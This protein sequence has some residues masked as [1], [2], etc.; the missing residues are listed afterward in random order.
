M[1]E[2]D[3]GTLRKVEWTEIC[4]WLILLRCFRM[5]IGFRLLLLATAGA[6]ATV[7]GW[8]LILWVFSGDPRIEVLS[9]N[10]ILADE[11]SI[12]DTDFFLPAAGDPRI[13]ASSGDPL[14][15]L[16][17]LVP[18]APGFSQGAEGVSGDPRIEFLSGDPWSALT[19]LVP[20][21]L[22]FSQGAM[23]VLDDTGKSVVERSGDP[24]LGTWGQLSRPLREVFGFPIFTGNGATLQAGEG[25]PIANLACFLLCGLWGLVVWAFFGGAITRSAAVELAC[26]ERIGFGRMIGYARAR[27]RSYVG[28]P[29]L[30]LVVVL[31]FAFFMAIAGLALRTDFTRFLLAVI[32]PLM[33]VG[34]VSMTWLLVGLLFGWPLMFAATSVDGVDAIDAVSHSYAY[35]FQR[36]WRYLFYASVAVVLGSLGWLVVWNVAAAIIGL[37]YWAA[38]LGGG[39]TAVREIISGHLSDGSDSFGGDL[40][41]F[42][43]GCVKLLAVGYLYSYF[44]T[45]STAIYLLL[46]LDHDNKEMDEIFLDDEEDEPPQGLPPLTTD[47][48]GAPVVADE[49]E[50]EEEE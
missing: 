33:L 46:R 28:A 38:S 3:A 40:I 24:F 5:A 6:V 9:L 43:C 10:E 41:L 29:L 20:N 49:V 31:V 47:E 13:E 26:E 2:D 21:A 45:A 37:T 23:G 50:S 19:G 15:A 11:R 30:P 4:P 12:R 25:S 16:T 32:W 48:A 39:P 17:G 36:P 35:T 34:G 18:D 8:T 7:I 42:W 27:W 22:G 1:I 14:S 44:W